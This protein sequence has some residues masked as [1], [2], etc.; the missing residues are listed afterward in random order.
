MI[1]ASVTGSDDHPK[2]FPSKEVWAIQ[3]GTDWPDGIAVLM[4]FIAIIW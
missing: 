2:F 1:P 3:N 4:S